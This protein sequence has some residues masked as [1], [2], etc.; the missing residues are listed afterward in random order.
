MLQYWNGSKDKDKD[1]EDLEELAIYK[2]E[3]E[4]FWI[5]NIDERHT[6]IR[7]ENKYFWV[8]IAIELTEK[9]ILDVYLSFRAERNTFYS[10]EISFETHW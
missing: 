2:E 6:P 3:E 9:S 10:R 8:Y 4:D 1:T 5:Y 7:V